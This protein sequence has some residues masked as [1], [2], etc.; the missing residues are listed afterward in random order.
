MP[1][2]LRLHTFARQNYPFFSTQ[3][4]AVLF[5]PMYVVPAII[6]YFA[7]QVTRD[8]MKFK[9]ICAIAIMGLLDGLAGWFMVRWIVMCARAAVRSTFSLFLF[10]SE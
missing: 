7:G 1:K 10:A 5:L 9:Y 4:I 2:L 6:A 3:V 8:M